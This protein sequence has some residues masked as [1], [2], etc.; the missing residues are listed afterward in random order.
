MQRRFSVWCSACAALAISTGSPAQTSGESSE[1][2]DLSGSPV[3]LSLRSVGYYTDNFYNQPTDEASTLG[4]LINPEIGFLEESAKLQVMG[5]IDGEYGVFDLPGSEDDYL[6]G[7]ARL[8]IVSQGTARNQIR[9]GAAFD[10]GHDAFGVN[11][12][13]DAAARDDDLDRWNQTAGSL[14]YKYGT[15]GARLNVEVGVRALDKHYITNRSGTEVLNYE[16]RTGEYTLFYNYSPKTAALVDFSRTDYSFDRPF[17][18]VD[19]RGGELYRARAGMRWQATGKTGG[20]VRVGWRERTFDI[21]T[22]DIEGV[23]WEATL[24]WSPVP[25]TQVAFSTA[26]SEQQSY[27]SAA[28]VIDI[29]SFAVNWKYNLTARSRSTV[30]LERLNVEFDG[31]SRDDHINTAGIGLEH[32]LKRNFNIVAN[33]GMTQRSSTSFYRDYDRLNAFVGIRLGR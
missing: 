21:G 19:T 1:D 24:D 6:D 31:S 17:G 13:E 26:R 27:A 2:T 28:R 30:T 18:A 20:D 32:L 23:D 5:K 16:A 29:A 3:T 14:H 33:L 11:R 7:G 12:T 4:A 9:I 22:P 8:R 10:H 15:A 25:R